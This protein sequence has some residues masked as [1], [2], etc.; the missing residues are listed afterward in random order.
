MDRH[1]AMEFF[2]HTHS[3]LNEAVP[4]I[5]VALRRMETA[6]T[7]APEAVEE[8]LGAVDRLRDEA[9]DHF[10]AEEITLFPVL[11]KALPELE[12]PVTGLLAEHDDMRY[13]LN[14]L[15]KALGRVTADR[16]AIREAL[17]Y[18]TNYTRCMADHSSLEDRTL[19]RYASEHLGEAQLNEMGARLEEVQG[20]SASR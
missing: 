6:A 1:P 2:F 8:L 10:R 7:L 4:K 16:T 17:T 9:E 15:R 18:A 14:G 3:E 19:Y 20:R 11:I 5:E 13:C 12:G